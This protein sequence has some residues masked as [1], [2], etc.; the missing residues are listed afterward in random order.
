MQN[1]ALL[2]DASAFSVSQFPF[3]CAPGFGFH[4]LGFHLFINDDYFLLSL[5]LGD[6]T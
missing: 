2:M 4:V 3:V 1:L 5:N 6:I